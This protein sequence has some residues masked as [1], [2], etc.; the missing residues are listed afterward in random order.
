ME[1][2]AIYGMFD[3]RDGIIRYVGQT[4]QFP[5]K[6][7]LWLHSSNAEAMRGNNLAS[8][9]AR[10]ILTL[11]DDGVLPEITILEMTTRD[12]AMSRERFWIEH[13]V[14]EGA[15]MVNST[16]CQESVSSQYWR[17]VFEERI[18]QIRRESEQA[19]KYVAR[20][21]EPEKADM[22]RA[23]RE[24]LGISQTDLAK[25]LG[26][27]NSTVSLWESCKRSPPPGID[28]LLDKV[29]ADIESERRG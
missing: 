26:Y 14:V 27:N 10:W 12:A 3:P 29:R 17:S 21:I 16:F 2:V 20:P 1:D 4:R 11:A 8:H 23:F 22:I 5:L 28:V 15:D 19:P 18:E 6:R 25:R 7:R 9:A 24:S 13:F